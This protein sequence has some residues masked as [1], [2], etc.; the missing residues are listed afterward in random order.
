MA[1]H[2]NKINETEK[3][4]SVKRN[5]RQKSEINPI[6]KDYGLQAASKKGKSSPA[7]R[8]LLE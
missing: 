1:I 7:E 3:K 4:I 5:R 6:D 8:K 2:S